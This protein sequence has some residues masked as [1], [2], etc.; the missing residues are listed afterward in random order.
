[1]YC[2]L[3]TQST[4]IAQPSRFFDG[5]LCGYASARRATKGLCVLQAYVD[6]S[7]THTGEKRLVLAGYVHRIDVWKE[8]SDEWAKALAEPRRL[9][10]LHMTE[11]FHGWSRSEREAK[12]LRLAG[13]IRKFRPISIECSISSRDYKAVVEPY[14]PYDLRHPYFPCFFGLVV[15]SARMVEELGLQGPLDFVFDERGNVGPNAVIW[16][17]AIKQWQGPSIKKILGG[18]P[19]FKDDEEVLPLQAA[20]MLVWH[21]RLVMEPTCSEL[22]KTFAESLHSRHIVT[23]IPRS[24]LEE[25][26]TAFAKV[27]GIERTRGKRGSVKKVAAEISRSVPPERLIPAIESM[28]KKLRWIQLAQAVLRRVGMRKLAKKLGKRAVLIK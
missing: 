4:I 7:D 28:R 15:S 17:E 18:P 22:Q 2:S 19:I 6:D 10:A 9:S 23:E 12:L 16:Y 1:M 13:V 11:S 27:P 5:I 25:W 3:Q 21:R 24:M 14:A 26:A 8:F 20:D